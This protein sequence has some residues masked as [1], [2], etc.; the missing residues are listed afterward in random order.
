MR[1]RGSR[2]ESLDQ[3]WDEGKVY[4]VV[5]EVCGNQLAVQTDK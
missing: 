2:G 4:Q 5:Q 1:L 3:R